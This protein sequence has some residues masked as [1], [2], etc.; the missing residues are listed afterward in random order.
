MSTDTVA[1][2][3][4]AELMALAL[5]YGDLCFKCGE[6]DGLDGYR[7]LST[8]RADAYAAIE[9]A[10]RRAVDGLGDSQPVAD[11]SMRD[12]VDL[13]II[14]AVPRKYIGDEAILALQR[15]AASIGIVNRVA[16]WDH[17][18]MFELRDMIVDRAIA[19][20]AKEADQRAEPASVQALREAD[21][22]FC[23]LERRTIY[24]DSDIKAVHAKIRAALA[25]HPS[26]DQNHSG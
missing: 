10:I 22:I 19:A 26:T 12:L 25:A 8:R 18:A 9:Q 7:E 2:K 16:C 5:D 6:H 23:W 20:Q 15:I 1:D 14:G 13:P 17:M 3:I 21:R 24:Q 4:T 11:E